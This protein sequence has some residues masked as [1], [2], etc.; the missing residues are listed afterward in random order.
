MRR[1]LS[2]TLKRTF[3]RTRPCWCPDLGLSACR[4]VSNKCLLSISTRV[5][6]SPHHSHPHTQPETHL[7]SFKLSNCIQ[8]AL[9]SP[10]A[11][12]T[13]PHSE[14]GGL[15][16]SLSSATHSA[17]VYTCMLSRSVMSDP[18]QPHGLWP[19]MLLCLWDLI[20]KN[21]GVG[22]LFPPPGDLPNRGFESLSPSVLVGGF[23][24]TESCGSHS[25]KTHS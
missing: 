4:T 23:F 13:N 1:R 17:N 10:G 19:T 16:L 12:E 18:V 2:G 7:T 20:G 8:V 22:L 14:G 15:G 9:G 6:A 24:T 25:A 3:T 11:Q 5:W 21:T